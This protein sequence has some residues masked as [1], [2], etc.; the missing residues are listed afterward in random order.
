MTVIV[1]FGLVV[2]LGW[3]TLRQ[4]ELQARLDR[5]ERRPEP[6]PTG[7]EAPLAEID[8]VLRAAATKAAPAAIQQPDPEPQ[9]S[10]EPIADEAAP[11]PARQLPSSPMDWKILKKT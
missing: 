11:P 10:P 6:S 7:F 1:F 8:A 2:W 9:A 3:L 4:G 5:L